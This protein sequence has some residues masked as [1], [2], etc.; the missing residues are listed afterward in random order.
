APTHRPA[1]KSLT[2]SV[3]LPGYLRYPAEE[4]PVQNASLNLLEGSTLTLG[5]AVNRPLAS[6]QMRVENDKPVPL[7]VKGDTFRTGALKLDGRSHTAFSWRDELGLDVATPWVLSLQTQKDLA[8]RVDIPDMS[9]ELSIL[10]TDVLPLRVVAT[11]DFGVKESGYAWEL[12]SFVDATN[13]PV[14]GEFHLPA[15]TPQEKRLTNAF[16]FSPAVLRVPPDTTVEVRAQA[17]DFLPGRKPSESQTFHISIVSVAKH[18]ELV[19]QQLEAIFSRLEEITRSEEAVESKTG[20]LKHQT[21]EKLASDEAA[22]KAGDISE[23]QAKTARQ[24]EQLAQEGVKAVAEALRNPTFKEQQLKEWAQALNQMR[25]ISQGDMKNAQ[26]SLRSAQ[27]SQS[28]RSEQLAKAQESEQDALESLQEL[29]KKMNENLDSLQ[30]QT[31]AQRLRKLAGT[32]QDIGGKINKMVPDTIGLLPKELPPRLKKANDSLAKDQGGARNEAQTV[33]EE[34]SRFFERT[35]KANYGVVS[36]EMKQQ[37]VGEELDRV[38]KLIDSNIAMEAMGNLVTWTKKFNAWA[39]VLD[40]P[41][42]GGGGGGGGGQ[43]GEDLLK[44]LMAYVRM[45]G[46]EVNIHDRTRLLDEHRANDPGFSSAVKKLADNQRDLRGDLTRMQLENKLGAIA[47]LIVDAQDST[48][49]AESLLFDIKTDEPTRKA[50]MLAVQHFSDIINLINEQI[51]R[52]G[53]GQG[54][55]GEQQDMASLLQMIQQ[56]QPGMGT[57]PGQSPGGNM[58]GGTTDRPNTGMPGDSKGLLP[59]TRGTTKSSGTTRPM[60]AEFRE[61]LEQYFKAV[62]QLPNK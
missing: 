49:E 32:E 17:V 52:N 45:R 26:Q 7:D 61:A 6:A 33:Q 12:V 48:R 11:D 51:Q 21:D 28:E 25:S 3:M 14:K 16:A 37:S 46:A 27:R 41:Q 38:R 29:Q 42:E 9:T 59:G 53:G 19:R 43:G 50:E 23:E 13:A 56:M 2:A 24:L 35:Q 8:P 44:L 58:S 4:K 5:G 55:P 15:A 31:L 47:D 57:L 1:L 10:E 34:M 62:E 18:A 54:S 36:L 30:A 40:P 20:D 22:Q 39:E 60:P